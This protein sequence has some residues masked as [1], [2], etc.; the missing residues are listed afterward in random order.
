MFPPAFPAA[1]A[2]PPPTAAGA[3][4]CA[5]GLADVLPGRPPRRSTQDQTADRAETAFVARNRPR[6]RSAGGESAQPAPHGLLVLGRG[7]A[8]GGAALAWAPRR[9]RRG[10]RGLGLH[11]ATR[12]R[13]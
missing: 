8:L 12:A 11:E 2:S 10:R 9:A 5:R 4:R 7:A 13:H 3:P 6:D 1:S